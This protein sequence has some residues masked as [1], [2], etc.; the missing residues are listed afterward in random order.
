LVDVS[1]RVIADHLRCL[2]FALT[3]GAIPSN[4]GRGYVLR[5][6][7]RRAVRYGRQYMNMHGPFLCDLVPT[8]VEH[9]GDI[10][11][12]LRSASGGKNVRHVTELMRDEETS[13]IRTLDRGIKLFEE[14]AEYARGHHHGKISGEDAFRLHDTYGFPIDLTELMA[15]EQ[16]LTI[17]VGEYER[18]MGEAKDR[19]RAVSA[20]VAPLFHD[21]DRLANP[22][23]DSAKYLPTLRCDTTIEV[24]SGVTIVNRTPMIQFSTQ[25]T[26]FY[27]E[28][29][30]QVSD[31][32]WVKTDHGAGRITSVA[33]SGHTILHTAAITHGHITAG[34]CA[35]EVDPKHRQPTMQNH[36]S[37]HILNWA[38]RDVLGEHVQQ[39]GSLV[40]PE[41]TRFDFSHSKQLSEDELSRIERHVKSQISNALP[42]L[43]NPEVDQQKAREINTLRAVFGEKYPDQVRVVSIGADIDAMLRDPTNPR[44]MQHSVEFCGGT[45]LK[46]TKEAEEFVLISEEG[47]AKGVRRVVGVTAEKAREAIQRGEVFLQIADEL[48]TGGQAA[49]GT[50][51]AL[52]H[53]HASVG[54]PPGGP[55]DLARLLKEIAE[56]QIPI[57]TRHTLA[58]QIAVLQEAA[59]EHQKKSTAQAQRGAVEAVADLLA[60]KAVD[61][62]GVTVL[63]AEVPHGNADALRSGIDYVRNK[64]GSSGV[65]LATVDDGKVTLVAGMSK[66]LVDRGIKAGDLIK[67]ICPLVGGKGGGRPDMAQ[68]GG[69]DPKGLAEALERAREWLNEKLS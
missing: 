60:S 2:V 45:H 18:L 34:P 30:G 65:L 25:Q 13:F 8:V 27:A 11:P 1:Y 43:T 52:K 16:G 24:C 19:A 44:W 40:D 22:C 32:G 59:K 50:P 62:A 3:D 35:L 53:A 67:E 49:S 63:V 37:T 64:K 17:D 57:L 42:V 39:K 29:G 15:E 7:L 20:E 47:V 54:M 28:Q 26:C 55:Y 36:T 31:I 69:T 33:R 6:I 66:D 10:F 38:L 23:D 56:A 48:R 14:A 12:E 9:M 46:N 68:G 61:V 4:E 21:I 5:R 51:A 58:G 41:K